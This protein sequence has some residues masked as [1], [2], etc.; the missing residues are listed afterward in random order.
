MIRH[1][2]L[3]LKAQ[4]FLGEDLA[5]GPGKADLLESIDRNGSISAGGRALGITYRRAWFLI[6]TMNRCWR[7]PLVVA[8][9]GKGARLSDLGRQVL[10]LYRGLERE[11]GVVAAGDDVETLSA[12]L[13]PGVP[14]NALPAAAPAKRAAR[15]SA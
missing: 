3:K 12:L 15:K 2:T 14:P 11:L 9:A 6:D 5:I 8:D 13:R 4:L 1:G 7:E 10:D